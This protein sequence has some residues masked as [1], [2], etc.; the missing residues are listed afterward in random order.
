MVSGLFYDGRII[1]FYFFI[2]IFIFVRE[3]VD[4]IPKKTYIFVCFFF[5]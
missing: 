2:F 1:F 5:F 3:L 4:K